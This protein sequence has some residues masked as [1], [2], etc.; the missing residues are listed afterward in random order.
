MSKMNLTTERELV[1]HLRDA[2]K[3]VDAG[4]PGAT[5]IL[6]EAVRVI[7]SVADDDDA[8]M[9]SLRAQ[10]QLKM[11][12]VP[13]AWLDAFVA[14]YAR[15]RVP[16]IDRRATGASMWLD[17]SEEWRS[18]RMAKLAE[19]GTDDGSEALAFYVRKMEGRRRSHVT[20]IAQV[21]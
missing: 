3:A 14:A 1:T 16:E 5:D 12:Q 7:V 11:L 6:V 18:T 2:L 15:D 9:A 13:K 20:A 4:A 10:W 21:A 19:W 17:N 8:Y